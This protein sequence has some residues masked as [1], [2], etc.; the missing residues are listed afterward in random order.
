MSESQPA[1]KNDASMADASSSEESAPEP[2][3]FDEL[4]AAV[5]GPR[6]RKLPVT[7]TYDENHTHAAKQAE[8]KRIKAA[9]NKA[10]REEAATSAAKRKT[11]SGEE[12][13][14]AAAPVKKKKK[15][16]TTKA[17]EKTP[18]QKKQKTT[19]EKV[20]GA[21][22][23]FLAALR[24]DFP[25]PKT[26]AVAK[27]RKP[28]EY[29]SA[30]FNV[31]PSRTLTGEEAQSFAEYLDELFEKSNALIESR[32]ADRGFTVKLSRAQ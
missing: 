28:S 13:G 32:F 25:E 12:E 24:G 21:A 4:A 14:D 19:V 17:E 3:T 10:R 2:P 22:S 8:V 27:K 20:I 29:I 1:E 18:A 11:G 26:T 31:K 30:K 15:T 16:M 7:F 6:K 5:N 9:A 23:A